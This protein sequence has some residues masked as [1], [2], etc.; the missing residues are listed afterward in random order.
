MA[1]PC[2]LSKRG[3]TKKPWDYKKL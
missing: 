3:Q 2:R 1:E